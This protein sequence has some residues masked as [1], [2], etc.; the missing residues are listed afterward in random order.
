MKKWL[1]RLVLLIPS[2]GLCQNSPD[3]LEFY[4]LTFAGNISAM[5]ATQLQKADRL[6]KT[7]YFFTEKFK[8]DY[9][10]F[11]VKKENNN[12]V[13]YDYELYL[14]AGRNTII[15]NIKEEKNRFVSI[16]IISSPSGICES[17]Y[18][19]MILMDVTKSTS[20]DFFTLSAVQCY[21]ENGQVSSSSKCKARYSIKGN[22]LNIRTTNYKE[23]SDCIKSG[24]YMYR[25]G[26]Y[27]RIK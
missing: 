6:G 10:L 22:I 27:V 18:E 8:E 14:H 24:K 13:V 16:Q 12:W 23:L 9:G 21:D 15:G 19:R 11:L 20:I 25:K 26:K 7:D 2:I 4:P 5:E 17:H 1:C 3:T